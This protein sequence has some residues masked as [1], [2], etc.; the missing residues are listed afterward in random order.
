M[1][2]GVIGIS[3]ENEENYK[4]KF[5]FRVL[6]GGNEKVC[7][8]LLELIENIEETKLEDFFIKILEKHI[9]GERLWYI[10]K[11]ECNRNINELIQKDLTPFTDAYFHNII[12]V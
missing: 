1:G 3:K 8:I 11:N 12:I 6:S 9:T 5:I 2:N 4:R 10:Y 7:S